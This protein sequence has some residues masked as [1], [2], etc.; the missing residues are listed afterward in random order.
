[1]EYFTLATAGLL[2]QKKIIED[3]TS[4]VREDELYVEKAKALATKKN[5]PALKSS[6]TQ[7][8]SKKFKG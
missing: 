8:F 5:R 1:M 6:I 3:V 7:F 2:S 4:N